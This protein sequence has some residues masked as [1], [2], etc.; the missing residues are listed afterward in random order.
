MCTSS[1]C[2]NN[3]NFLAA[4]G[5]RSSV[6]LRWIASTRPP[7]GCGSWK[8]GRKG[9]EDFSR[10]E[11]RERKDG[12]GAENLACEKDMRNV[13]EHRDCCSRYATCCYHEEYF[14]FARC[15]VYGDPRQ[16][17]A[18]GEHSPLVSSLFFESECRPQR[19][20]VS[21]V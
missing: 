21:S 6:W 10:K 17:N 14:I 20:N 16:E 8:E 9:K 11:T 2:C 12:N 5:S 18:S 3:N 13:A 7:R 19:E 15:M 1:H 4:R